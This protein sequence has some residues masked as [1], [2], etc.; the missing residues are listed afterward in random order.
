MAN[1]RI[2]PGQ[3]RAEGLSARRRAARGAARS[4]PRPSELGPRLW[5]WTRASVTR[6][7]P[8]GRTAGAV[9][10]CASAGEPRS[11]AGRS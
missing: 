3:R 10:V 4:L 2:T 9:A 6:G 8:R 5:E 1:T 11:Y 7:G